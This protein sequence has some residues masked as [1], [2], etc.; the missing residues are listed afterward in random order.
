MMREELARL[1]IMRFREIVEERTDDKDA[2]AVVEEVIHRD[3]RPLLSEY[4]SYDLME[5]DFDTFAAE[6]LVNW[7]DDFREAYIAEM[8]A[9]GSVRRLISKY[10]YAR[11][12]RALRVLEA[13][14]QQLESRIRQY[15]YVV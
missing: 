9:G 4:F 2:R 7:V 3:L 12:G 1:S 14:A 5:F 15:A 6:L 11:Y 10:R 8:E 13:V